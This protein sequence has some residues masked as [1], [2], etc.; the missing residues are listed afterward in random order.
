[1]VTLTLSYWKGWCLAFFWW[2]WHF[3][4]P[5]VRCWNHS[6]CQRLRGLSGQDGYVYQNPCQRRNCRKGQSRF[7]SIA[8]TRLD[9]EKSWKNI[10]QHPITRNAVFRR[11]KNMKKHPKNTPWKINME[12]TAI[13]HLCSGK[14]SE[15]NLHEEVFQPLVFRGVLSSTSRMVKLGCYQSR[16]LEE[17]FGA[18]AWSIGRIWRCR[19]H[20]VLFGKNWWF[21]A[22]WHVCVCLSDIV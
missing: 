12:P 16:L 14:W 5:E 18:A 10:I 15:P 7:F 8:K 4:K 1:M 6:D 17:L 11:K 13:T 20:A 9:A 3:R 2:E 22:C 19:N 21:I